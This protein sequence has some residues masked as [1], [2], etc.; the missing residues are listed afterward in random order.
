MSRPKLEKPFVLQSTSKMAKHLASEIFVSNN[1]KAIKL[2][3]I[4]LEEVYA[5]GMARGWMAAKKEET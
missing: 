2:I 4:F 5:A 3:E 1:K